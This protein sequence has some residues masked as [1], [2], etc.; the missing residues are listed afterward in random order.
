MALVPT[1]VTSLSEVQAAEWIPP[2]SPKPHV[3]ALGEPGTLS[4]AEE[5]GSP[6]RGPS[7]SEPLVWV[8]AGDTGAVG[9]ELRV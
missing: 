6:Q 1:E 9:L 7:T 8:Q 4:W 5:P 2:T 3:P